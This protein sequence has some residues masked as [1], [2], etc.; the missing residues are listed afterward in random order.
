[1]GAEQGISVDYCGGIRAYV[2]LSLVDYIDYDRPPVW[3]SVG[4]EYTHACEAAIGGT[5]ALLRGNY[6]DLLENH[7]QGLDHLDRLW[8]IRRSPTRVALLC[9]RDNILDM[10]GAPHVLGA[11]HPDIIPPNWYKRYYILP[12]RRFADLRL[13]SFLAYLGIR[14]PNLPEPLLI[15]SG[16]FI[17][18]RGLVRA[19]LGVVRELRSQGIDD[20]SSKLVC[21]T[22]SGSGVFGFLGCSLGA[23]RVHF[24]DIDNRANE[25]ISR[26]IRRLAPSCG[27]SVHQ[28]DIFPSDNLQVDTVLANAPWK[29]IYRQEMEHHFCDRGRA[30]IDRFF[31]LV[32]GRL[33]S[34]GTIYLFYG[35]DG[36]DH[37][38]NLATGFRIREYSVETASGARCCLFR[39]QRT[40]PQ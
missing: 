16:V 40:E 3:F 18:D 17:P 37:I 19:F 22:F 1:M 32:R 12:L 36:R 2:P 7:F 39:L 23:K 31:S 28:A 30:T 24:V 26:N 13:H 15:L 21:D 20:F 35:L 8:A 33:R 38:Y 10:E 29:D 34:G 25:C 4:E 11:N 27:T 6:Q 14:I 5:L 9:T